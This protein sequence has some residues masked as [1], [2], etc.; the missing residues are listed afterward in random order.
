V[1]L[2]GSL[3]TAFAG[4]S[5]VSPAKSEPAAPA[6]TALAFAVP[7]DDHNALEPVRPSV[8]PPSATP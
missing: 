5:F 4:F 6:T 8:A 2:A 3:L 7:I 1:A